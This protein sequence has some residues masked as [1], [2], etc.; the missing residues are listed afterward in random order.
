MDLLI[1]RTQGQQ[2]LGKRFGQIVR[3]LLLVQRL[4]NKLLEDLGGQSLGQGIDGDDA[5]GD[6]GPP[7][8]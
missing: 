6:L 1:G 5:A 8:R 2:G 4:K 7:A 3:Q